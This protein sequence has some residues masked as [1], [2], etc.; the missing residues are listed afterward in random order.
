MRQ[1]CVDRGISLLALALQFCLR[2]QRIQGNPLGSQNVAELEVNGRA[3]TEPLAEELF[4]EFARAG[5]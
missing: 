2:E 5:L 4:A 3:V 1:W